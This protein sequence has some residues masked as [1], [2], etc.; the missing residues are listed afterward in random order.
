L[1]FDVSDEDVGLNSLCHLL[2]CY[3][4]SSREVAALGLMC[5]FSTQD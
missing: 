4:S 5:E 2:A 3:L 1:I